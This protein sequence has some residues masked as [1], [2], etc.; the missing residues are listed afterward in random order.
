MVDLDMMQPDWKF[1]QNHAQANKPG[2]LMTSSILT[3]VMSSVLA[4]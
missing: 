3:Q 2:L 1:A 4:V